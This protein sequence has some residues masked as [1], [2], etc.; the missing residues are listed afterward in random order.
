MRVVRVYVVL[1]NLKNSIAC[2]C[3]PR[4]DLLGIC[5]GMHEI[6]DRICD[7]AFQVALYFVT[8]I[9]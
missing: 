1:C 5:V 2:A 8:T 7:L 9:Q 3:L 6:G 4:G